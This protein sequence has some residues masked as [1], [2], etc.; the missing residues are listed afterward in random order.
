MFS[1]PLIIIH[2]WS[3]SSRSF[4]KLAQLIES[5]TGRTAQEINLADYLSM[6]DAISFYDLAAAMQNA[7]RLS[8]LPHS[9]AS[10]DVIAHSAGGLVVRTWLQLYF[11]AGNSPIKNLV[12]L[13]PANFGS[14]LAHKGRAFYGRILK[15]F[16]GERMFQVG[17]QLLKELELASPFTFEL[18]LA[19]RFNE[20]SYYGPGKILCTV[21]CGN[22]GYSGISAAA[23]EDGSDG[24]VRVA[25]ANLNC[26]LL[27]I[28]FS[29]DPLHPNYNYLQAS[30]STA[31]AIMDGENHHT[32]VGG[33]PDFSNPQTLEFIIQG[34]HIKDQQFAAWCTKLERHNQLMMNANLS[35]QSK[36]GFQNTLCQVENQFGQ[37]I[38]EYFLEFYGIGLNEKKVAELFHASLIQ[39]VHAYSENHS[40]RSLYIDC[41]ALYQ[42]FA[43]MN[44]HLLLSLTAYPALNQQGDV[45]YRTF[46]DSEIGSI[47]ISKAELA[48]LFQE[49]RSLL[50]RI[51]L[52]REQ[53]SKIFQIK[54]YTEV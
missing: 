21:L 39:S 10:V 15:G 13:A 9:P 5:Q 36:H 25:A 50:V 19:D 47:A 38:E 8:G 18:A 35:I 41:T 49:N 51:K 45:G 2:G 23:N 53:S 37:A 12:L 34:L 46:T 40:Y 22:T 43:A 3:D 52:R 48:S 14:Q 6:D 11:S 26:A 42:T 44:E 29:N 17:A 31:F 7:W 30:G 24:T 27:D 4:H 1:K 54:P 28:D 33:E 16:S 20:H 32:I